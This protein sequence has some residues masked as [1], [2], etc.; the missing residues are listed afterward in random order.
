VSMFA[1]TPLLQLSILIID[2]TKQK[3]VITV[4]QII[5]QF[6]FHFTLFTNTCTIN[7][8]IKVYNIWNKNKHDNALKLLLFFLLLS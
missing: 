8:A 6:F 2:L 7:M 1:I 5:L 4:W 3:C